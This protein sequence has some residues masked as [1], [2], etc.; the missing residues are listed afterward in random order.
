[1]NRRRPRLALPFT[2]LSAADTVRLVAGEDYRYTLTGPRLEQWLPGFLS[3]LDGKQALE[4]ALASVPAEQREAALKVVERLY[5]ERVL[6]DGPAPAAHAPTRYRLVAEGSGRLQKELENS[7][8]LEPSS[9][10]P[11]LCQDRLDYDEALQFNHRCRHAGLPF[12]WASYGPMSRAYVSPLF[13]ADAGPCL[14]CLL[15]NFRRLSPAPEI[16]DHLQ[17]HARA[18]GDIRPVPSSLAPQEE[19]FPEEGIAILANLIRWKTA[20][21]GQREPP[22]VLYRLH[23]LERD[24]FEV[25]SHRVF[26]DPECPECHV[27]PRTM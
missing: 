23:V 15:R 5:G 3:G 19:G 25:S 22:V 14:N 6:V 11:V 7:P 13:L 9:S 17:E 16:Y 21:A 12:L 10:L 2:I 20:Q 26:A 27:A 1:M 4:N 18:G 8:P 24:T